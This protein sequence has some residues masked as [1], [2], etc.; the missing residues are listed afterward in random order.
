MKKIIFFIENKWAFGSIHY[1]L[2]KEL[3]KYGIDAELLDWDKTY[4]IDE[5]LNIC[6]NIDYFVTTTV[7]IGFL[8]NYQI[9]L[10]K[11][12]GVAHAQWDI[13]LAAKNLGLNIFNKIHKY[14]V[15]STILNIKSK[16]FGI[17]RNPDIVPVGINFNRFY[18]DPSTSLRSAGIAG[19]Y[20]S[21]NFF[22]QEIKRGY[23][24]KLAVNIA[25]IEYKN[26]KFYH[27]LSMPSFYRSIDCIITASTEEGAGLP[28]MEA[29][30]AG[31]LCIGTPV[32]YFETNG[33]MGGGII[34]SIDKD[35]FVNE[36]LDTLIYYKNNPKIYNKKCLDIQEYARENY[37]WSKHIESWVNFLM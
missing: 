32:G 22:G 26:H 31:R 12:I 36:V 33:K 1:S 28:M 29:A 24:A 2:C 27:Y 9:P 5:M 16:E 10:D 17:A 21:Y 30:A 3:H 25:D 13:L 4:E 14:G 6:D 15:V 37:D 35:K 8:L 23:L 11:I 19:A 20:E 7:G 34:A 18:S